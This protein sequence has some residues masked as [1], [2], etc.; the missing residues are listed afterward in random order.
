MNVI[1]KIV[2]IFTV[3][4]TFTV[5]F[6]LRS[7]P[8]GSNWYNYTVLYVLNTAAAGT[9]EQ[10]LEENGIKDYVSL[11]NQRVPIMLRRNSI[12]ESMLRVNIQDESN[13]YLITRQ[14]YFYDSTGK[15]SLYYI[16]SDQT[17]N[18][19]K[20]VNDLAKNGIKAGID[21]TVAY[22]W[23]LP[24]VILILVFV[25]LF[26]AKNKSMYFFCAAFPCIYTFCNTFHAAALASIILILCIFLYTNIYNRRG[27][28]N[29]FIRQYFILITLFIS[30]VTAFSA[31]LSSGFIF[32]LNIAGVISMS[33]LCSKAHNY[34][35][36]K[37]QFQPVLIRS[38]KQVSMYGGKRRSVLPAAVCACVLIF[39]YIALGSV[40]D[41]I[42][43]KSGGKNLLLPGK[44]DL[45][46]QRLPSFDDY[47]RWI[48]NV[49]T[50][51]YRSLNEDIDETDTVVYPRYTDDGSTITRYDEILT[52]DKAFKDNVYKDIDRLD[53]NSIE[54]VIKVQGSGFKAGYKDNVS[55]NVS[56]FSIIMMIIEFCML[57][58]IYFSAMIGKG[59]KR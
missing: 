52:Y 9:I 31:G 43:G 14:N 51:P 11:G 57:L 6:L 39:G 22:M 25:L 16:K 55:Y 46:D 59:G 40:K 7:V 38:A 17:K 27:A 32:I 49:K 53:F 35:L 30:V 29:K 18:L 19:T 44:S 15:Y 34:K 20:V 10:T 13:A 47:S 56:I 3:I 48:W 42:T 41:G 36:S 50:Y 12:E 2:L 24:A 23:F 1:K 58:F 4:I 26:F 21:S 5:T 33:I 54:K 37:S 8:H 45:A 28:A